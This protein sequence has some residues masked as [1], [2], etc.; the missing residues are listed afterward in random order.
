[1]EIAPLCISFEISLGSHSEFREPKPKRFVPSC[2]GK[3]LMK[4]PAYDREQPMSII[5]FGRTARP[6]TK[7]CQDCRFRIGK[8]PMSWKCGINGNYTHTESLSWGDCGEAKVL[9]QPR[10]PS[11]WSRLGDV[12]IDRIK[13]K[14]E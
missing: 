14:T 10:Q 4:E 6:A 12:I 2:L 13:G 1:M 8:D 11:F 7:S 5:P 3:C 9:W